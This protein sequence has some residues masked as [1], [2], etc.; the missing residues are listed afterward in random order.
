MEWLQLITFLSYLCTQ[1]DLNKEQIDSK[2]FE[3]Y[4]KIVYICTASL[5]TYL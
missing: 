3:F 4:L 2:I 5:L 1:E